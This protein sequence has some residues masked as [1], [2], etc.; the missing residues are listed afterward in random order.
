M[1]QL[2]RAGKLRVAARFTLNARDGT[3]S[4]AAGHYT[5]RLD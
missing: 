5:L 1:R 2:R 3:R 4:T